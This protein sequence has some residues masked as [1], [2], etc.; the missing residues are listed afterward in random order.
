MDELDLIRSFRSD[1]PAPSPAAV[2]HAERAWRR[3]RPRR[4]RWAPR[5]AVAAALAAAALIAAIAIPGSDTGRIGPAE[6]TAAETLRRAADAQHGELP[7]PLRAG[8]FWYVR[9]R[10]ASII[11]G[12]ESGYT[13]IQPE[14][15]E[16][17]VAADGTRRSVIRPAGPLRF[18]GPRDRRRWEAAGS[19]EL[20]GRGVQDYR[21]RAP[22]KGPFYFADQPMSYADLLGLPRDA[23]ALYGRIRSAA[24]ECE[25][26]PSVDRESFVIVGDMLRDNPI[27]DD[28]RAAFLRAAAFIPGIQLVARERDVAG[29]P[30]IAV[31]HDHARHRHALVFD[32][33]SYRLLGDTDRVVAR[34]DY[35]DAAA[36]RLIGGRAYVESG[37]VTSQFARP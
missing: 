1:I 23:E 28:L 15:R 29:R 4:S 27:P 5:L 6:A 30:G 3:A 12:D 16:D 24:V 20:S 19:P 13:A 37:I 2:G 31:A 26:G 11:G 35:V 17:W 8:E 18:P 10:S 36:G 9:T 25:C 33:R 34:N 7:R 22:K 14:L 32:A 21:F